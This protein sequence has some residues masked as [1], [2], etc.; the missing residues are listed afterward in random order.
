MGF[1][2]QVIAKYLEHFG[3]GVADVKP[4]I[5]PSYDDHQIPPEDFEARWDLAN[6]AA[7]I[8]VKASYGD[9]FLRYDCRWSI[10]GL[11]RRLLLTY[12]RG[13]TFGSH[14]AF[15]TSYSGC[16]FAVIVLR[17]AQDCTVLLYCDASFA[18][19]LRASKFSSGTFVVIA[20]P[21]LTMSYDKTKRT[22]VPHRST[23]DDV[24]SLDEAAPSE[25]LPI[26]KFGKHVATF[27]AH[28]KSKPP[29]VVMLAG[30]GFVKQSFTILFFQMRQIIP[31]AKVS[32]VVVEDSEATIKI[33]TKGRS[34][35]LRHV[36]RT[37]VNLVWIH[38]VLLELNCKL[39]MGDT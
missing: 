4:A 39:V 32:F 28:T 25:G 18:D 7:T 22:A 33:S 1:M 36:Q 20:G 12:G 38:E 15:H 29:Q 23:V 24:L 16:C 31:P 10:G 9:C 2:C 3:K 34:A 30:C 11:A 27:L 13:S 35:K 6:K 19:D 26:M 14:H 21:M 8:V 5:T 37:L 17:K